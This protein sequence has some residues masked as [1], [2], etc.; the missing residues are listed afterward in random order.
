ML[1]TLR[2]NPQQEI[3]PTFFRKFVLEN[4]TKADIDKRA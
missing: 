1:Y 2:A 4:K 3:K